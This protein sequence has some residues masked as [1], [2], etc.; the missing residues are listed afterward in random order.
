MSRFAV[1]SLLGLLSLVGLLLFP[2]TAAAQAGGVI[3]GLVEDE[4]GGSCPA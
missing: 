1:G 3:S 2:V 4:T